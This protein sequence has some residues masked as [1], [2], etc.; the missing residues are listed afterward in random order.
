MDRYLSLVFVG[1]GQFAPVAIAL[2]LIVGLASLGALVTGTRRMTEANFLFGWS[3][4][5]T[6]FTVFGVIFATP[7]GILTI[8]LFVLAPFALFVAWRRGQALVVPGGWRI[9]LLALPLLAIAGAMHP[10]QWDE[11]SHWLP[12]P[13]FLLA[14]DGFPG[15]RNP[16]SGPNILAAYPYG[17]PLLNYLGG[18]VA[19]RFMEN[20]GGVLNIFLL[21][22]LAL[23]A[24]RSALRAA[25]YSEGDGEG[26]RLSWGLA[27]LVVLFATIFN[28]TFIQKIVL[29]AYSDVA[30]AVVMA[31]GTLA[32]FR[33]L[34]RLGEARQAAAWQEAW[35]FS[36]LMML[37][38]NLR[39]ANL[40]MFVILFLGLCLIVLRDPAIDW[41][42][43]AKLTPLLVG[44]ALIVYGVWRYH[45][46]AELLTFAGAEATFR[47]LA[48]WN[49]AEIPQILFKMLVVAGKKIGFFGVMLVACVFAVRGLIRL[50]S[51]FD[52]IAILCAAGF[53]G[54][55]AFLLLTYVG[56]FSRTDALRVVSYWRYNTHVG[57]LAVIFLAF[58]A[59]LLWRRHM[60][61]G[62]LPRWVPK[63]PVIL[64][65]V[66]PIAFAPKL[67]F[68]LEPPKPH[69]FAVAESLKT[70]LAAQSKLFVMDPKG[71][72]ESAVIS[73]YA[74]DKHGQPWM[75]AFHNPTP[76]NIKNYLE[77]IDA[78]GY[79]LVHSV[80][81]GVGEALGHDLRDDR[82]Y[83]LRREAKSWR[84]VRSWEKPRPAR[85]TAQSK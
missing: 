85:S 21:L 7:F 75:S 50:R 9:L 31:C 84:L 69:Y 28:P 10:S 17:W 11:F 20:L 62:R 53:I 82:S 4:A 79:L 41:R 30:T 3:L 83:L 76:L 29:T 14:T 16:L 37:F 6:A 57:L 40:V 44:P 56:H 15:L 81:V 12:A 51:D 55:N 47:P 42:R 46:T 74:L 64:V 48:L 19:G 63:V 58:G 70:L 68:D 39:Q 45:V 27:A 66:L 24:V 18:R 54:Y 26:R 52:R 33:L 78:G 38:V 60:P 71:T 77:R 23:L 8:G 36:L 25:G 67:R 59:V 43:F 80:V 49:L 35:Q 2:V 5:S 72:G 61:P 1:P 13:K 34:Q 73:R 22:G 65:L 32:G